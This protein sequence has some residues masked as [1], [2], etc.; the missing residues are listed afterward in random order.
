M[1]NTRVRILPCLFALI[2]V[3]GCRDGT[4]P[5]D[6]ALYRVETSSEHFHVLVRDS[7]TIADIES[8]LAADSWHGIVNGEL[9]R[10][11]GGFNQPWSW[12]MIPETVEIA[13]FTIELCDGQPSLVEADLDYWID[14]VGR[15]CP[16]GGEVVE[17]VD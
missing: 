13:D 4:A 9:A 11:D 10:G 5:V 3:A 16:W 6:G 14:T 17:R 2:V 15:Y 7:A 12:H 1:R 8:R